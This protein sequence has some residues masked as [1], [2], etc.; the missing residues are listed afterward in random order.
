M[1]ISGDVFYALRSLLQNKIRSK[2]C[3][4][5]PNYRGLRGHTY[6]LTIRFSWDA[7]NFRA[8]T[9]RRRE[10]W[11]VILKVKRERRSV[12]REV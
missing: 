9:Q 12:K 3:I 4:I 10:T 6:D 1:P 11:S 2:F 8:A 5:N 7:G